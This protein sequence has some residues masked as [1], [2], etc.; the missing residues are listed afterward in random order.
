MK[1]GQR[2]RVLLVIGI[3]SCVMAGCPPLQRSQHE[4]VATRATLEEA[5]WPFWPVLMQIHPLTRISVN[6]KSGG[7]MLEARAEFLDAD[8]VNSRA[9]G[10]VLLEL[11]DR[12]A[13][14]A[15]SALSNVWTVDLRDLKANATH[16]DAVTRTY[17]FRLELEP[18]QIPRQPELRIT[19]QGIDGATMSHRQDV[20]PY[21]LEPASGGGA[22]AAQD[23]VDNVDGSGNVPHN[24][25]EES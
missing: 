20:R 6:R 1:R 17:L 11:S 4:P 10:Q 24:I 25:D 9:C 19:F 15:S 16:F 14:D 21:I 12:E 8:G 22:D 23:A 3:T 5:N 18:E 2:L 7:M 13:V